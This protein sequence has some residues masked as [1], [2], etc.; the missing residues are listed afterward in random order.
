MSIT[1]EM[2]KG[3]LTQEMLEMMQTEETHR[4]WYL[5]S[6]EYIQVVSKY[7]ADQI[8]ILGK[9]V[10]VLEV[11]SSRG[12][13]L[14]VLKETHPFVGIEGS[15]VATKFATQLWGKRPNTKLIQCR[16]ENFEKLE[17][18]DVRV[19]LVLFANCLLY[20]KPEYVLKFISTFLEKTKATHFI[21]CSC[22]EKI[23][24]ESMYK[25]LSYK[26]FHVNLLGMSTLAKNRIIRVYSAEE[27]ADEH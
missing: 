24:A 1:A 19:D 5:E 18:K 27:I 3:E 23:T 26:Y 13:F 14:K 21:I 11:G 6:D 4:Y 8:D 20:L 9:N 15:K 25:C 22:R 12:S 7:M 16:F 10:S 17:G 2:F